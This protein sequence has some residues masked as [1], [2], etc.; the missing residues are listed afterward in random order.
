[1]ENYLALLEKWV[2]AMKTEV[3]VSKYKMMHF[4]IKNPIA[5]HN[6]GCTVGQSYFRWLKNS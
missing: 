1:M 3:N 5:D 4:V 6:I 2:E